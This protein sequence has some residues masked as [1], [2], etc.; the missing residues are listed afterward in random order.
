MATIPETVMR[1]IANANLTVMNE[2]KS[3]TVE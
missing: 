2:P 1:T 3:K